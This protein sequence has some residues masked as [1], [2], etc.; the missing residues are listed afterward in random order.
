MESRYKEKQRGREA[1]KLKL[2]NSRQVALKGPQGVCRGLENR[3]RHAPPR[4]QA[5]PVSCRQVCC[6]P[7]HR[8]LRRFKGCL[9]L[10]VQ[11]A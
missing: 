6:E 11:Y 2:S 7:P 9:C 8:H 3:R 4:Q 10:Q 1:V 5:L